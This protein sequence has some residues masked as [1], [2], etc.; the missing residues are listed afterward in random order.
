[1]AHGVT[2]EWDDI[3]VKMGNYKPLEKEPTSE[4]IYQENTENLEQ[5]DNK[6]AMNAQQLEEK[7][8]DD[9]D[10]DD[11]D[12]FLQQY[13][14]QRM[15][16]MKANAAKP[17]YGSVLEISKPEWEIEIQRAPADTF[18]V[19]CLYQ[20]HVPACQVLLE[21]FDRLA[22]KH[23][24]VKFIKAVATSCVE[25]FHDSHCPGIG[26]C[27]VIIVMVHYHGFVF[28]ARPLCRQ[29]PDLGRVEGCRHDGHLVKGAVEGVSH[30]AVRPVDT[31]R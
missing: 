3:Q 24:N 15:A 7:A 21:I 23:I 18:V 30:P 17:R 13:R 27:T 19:I 9:I 14:A 10:F 1:M 5:Y 6:F 4:Q 20:N 29:G 12:E 11:D 16:Q 8:E 31:G 28:A 2:T 22:R 26:G 25:N